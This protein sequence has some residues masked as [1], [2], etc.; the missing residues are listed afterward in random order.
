MDT[1]EINL[2]ICEDND[3]LLKVGSEETIKIETSGDI[4]LS[5]FMKHL[6]FLVEKKPKL[7]LKQIDIDDPKLQLIQKT[8]DEIAISFNNSINNENE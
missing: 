8:L 4:D 6:T 1:I 7:T 3:I 5:A 2:S